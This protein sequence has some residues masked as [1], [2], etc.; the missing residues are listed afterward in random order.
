[1]IQARIRPAEVNFTAADTAPV[2]DSVES[3]ATALIPDQAGRI[4]LRGLRVDPRN[5]KSE[6]RVDTTTEPP[7]VHVTEALTYTAHGYTDNAT[8]DFVAYGGH[9]L[10]VPHIASGKYTGPGSTI[11]IT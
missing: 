10:E 3:A 2:I 1:M 6:V 8:G 4:A 5:A 11:D 7:T 9:I